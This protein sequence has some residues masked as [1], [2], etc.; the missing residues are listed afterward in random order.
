MAVELVDGL[1]LMVA[2]R[3]FACLGAADSRSLR[4]DRSVR[5]Q[6]FARRSKTPFDGFWETCA[7]NPCNVF[8]LLIMVF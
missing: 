3:C 6:H 5:M 8:L 2:V 4:F 1:A 7:E